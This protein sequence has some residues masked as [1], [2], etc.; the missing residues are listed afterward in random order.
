MYI[1][2]GIAKCACCRDYESETRS[3]DA[4]PAQER[5]D[6]E[7]P[8]R[9]RRAQ[10]IDDAACNYRCRDS[11]ICKQGTEKYGKAGTRNVT[12]I[13]LDGPARAPHSSKQPIG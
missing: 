9:K 1:G 5:S 4:R 6:I 2:Y 3:E 11:L 7:H 13:V 8:G 12:E 10:R